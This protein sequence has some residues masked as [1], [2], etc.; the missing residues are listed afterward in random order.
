MLFHPAGS[1]GR[2]SASSSS[3]SILN[4]ERAAAGGL[5]RAA[6]RRALRS[7]CRMACASASRRASSSWPTAGSGVRQP[8]F[9]VE[10]GERPG[11]RFGITAPEQFGDILHLSLPRD[12]RADI[13]GALDFGP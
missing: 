4:S 1:G 9:V 12:V 7:N 13:A 5:F 11:Y 2:G 6:S 8:C 10:C 3:R